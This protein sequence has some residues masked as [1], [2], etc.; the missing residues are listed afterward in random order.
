M[1]CASAM[2][3]EDRPT[4][5]LLIRLKPP[6]PEKILQIEARILVTHQFDSCLQRQPG[7]TK[8][9]QDPERRRTTSA[10]HVV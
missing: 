8:E 10:L 5:I 7:K 3:N 6:A 2:L 1:D 9:I 4:L